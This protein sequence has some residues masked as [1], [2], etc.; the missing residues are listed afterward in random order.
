MIPLSRT[1]LVKQGSLAGWWV[2]AQEMEIPKGILISRARNREMDQTLI[3]DGIFPSAEAA[4]AFF[5]QNAPA[6]EWLD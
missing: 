2:R 1:G 4:E 5:Q 3:L 6:V